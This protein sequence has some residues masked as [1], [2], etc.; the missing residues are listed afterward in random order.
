[1]GE[2]LVPNGEGSAEVFRHD[3]GSA[4]TSR[5]TRLPSISA[6]LN[7]TADPYTFDGASSSPKPDPPF[8][9]RS[10]VSTSSG[11]GSYN[12]YSMPPLAGNDGAHPMFALGAAS[13]SPPGSHWVVS[14][15]SPS[16]RRS[17]TS[18]ALPNGN[19]LHPLPSGLSS[20]DGRPRSASTP[21]LSYPYG[22]GHT[23]PSGFALSSERGSSRADLGGKGMHTAGADGRWSP[24]VPEDFSRPR[25]V[26]IPTNVEQTSYRGNRTG[27][28]SFAKLPSMSEY[29]QPLPH[30]HPVRHGAHGNA[31]ALPRFAFLGP[32]DSPSALSSA[33]TDDD[34]LPTPLNY[35][36]KDSTY[37][38]VHPS[39]MAARQIPQL[40]T[41]NLG[42]DLP[43][44][45]IPAPLPA[46]L[47]QGRPGS[48]ATSE[49][50]AAS[51]M[52][53]PSPATAASPRNPAA[54]PTSKRSRQS[55][56]SNEDTDALPDPNPKDSQASPTDGTP[57][58]N[59]RYTCPHCP[60][61]FAR[62]SSLRI[63]M[64]SHTGEKPFTCNLCDRAFSVQSNLRRH[65]K[66]HKGAAGTDVL[67]PKVTAHPVAPHLVIPGSGSGEVTPSAASDS[68]GPNSA[69]SLSSAVSTET[70]TSMS[71]LDSIPTPSDVVRP[72]GSLLAA[73]G[74]KP[75]IFDERDEDAI[76]ASPDALVSQALA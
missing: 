59:G 69:I 39:A 37:R 2:A 45:P 56:T 55:L 14:P 61:R 7:Q 31:P 18:F 38:P 36:F 64:H 41:A 10:S 34:E 66:I 22:P 16:S 63:H 24:P 21:F 50:S 35:P 75:P 11:R 44:P 53:V 70:S 65:L 5:T 43:L 54:R 23:R 17:S 73:I 27:G 28:S 20:S 1:M 52:S 40:Q 76:M 33:T 48:P 67:A 29:E 58:E 71:S 26:S 42:S 32:S 3:A 9:D 62:P 13:Q 47:A 4:S 46:G 68:T 25:S 12:Q 49:S 15:S 51:P 72:N 6:L 74:Q 30:P 19:A 57:S 60:K 8:P